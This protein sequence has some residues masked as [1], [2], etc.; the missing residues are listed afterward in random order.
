MAQVYVLAEGLV[1]APAAR[2]YECIADFRQ[3]HPRFLPS[4]F[5]NL[6]VQEGGVGAGTVITFT[7]T[8]ARRTRYYRMRIDE[9]EPG[10]VLTESDLNS[11]MVSTWTVTPR[12]DNSL[13]RI[14]TRW[15]GASGI[16]GFFERTFAPRAMRRIY[17]EEL[18]RLDQYARSLAPV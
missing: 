5:S 17:A 18:R 2:V 7:A 15:N 13:V 3:H 11:S 4:N 8:A 12:G 1:R 6:E 10:R 14:E 16:K 9:P